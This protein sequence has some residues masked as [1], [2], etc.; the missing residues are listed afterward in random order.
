[1]EAHPVTIQAADLRQALATGLINALM[2]SAATGYDVKVW[3]RMSHFYDTR[4]W[5]PK[6][7]TLVNNAAFDQLDKPMQDR[8]GSLPP[9]RCAVGGGRRKRPNGTRTSLLFTV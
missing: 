1:V 9:P 2:T 6:N 5:I 8:S 7:V 3:D 4:T